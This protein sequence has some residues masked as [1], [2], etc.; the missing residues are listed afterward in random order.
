M[1]RKVKE[2]SH[3]SHACHKAIATPL[4]RSRVGSARINPEEGRWASSRKASALVWSGSLSIHQLDVWFQP[5]QLLNEQ[6]KHK[7]P[8]GIE[9]RVK[10]TNALA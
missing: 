9:D 8:Q 5:P 4:R 3:I 1:K 6:S 10:T 7:A 2:I